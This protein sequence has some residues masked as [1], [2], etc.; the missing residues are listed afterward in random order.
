MSF[1]AGYKSVLQI[2]KPFSIFPCFI[3][4]LRP[5]YMVILLHVTVKSRLLYSSHASL[6]IV[7][8]NAAD[9][10]QATDLWWAV[11]VGEQR[12]RWGEHVSYPSADIHFS[13]QPAGLHR[14]QERLVRWHRSKVY[15]NETLHKQRWLNEH[16]H[17]HRQTEIGIKL[18]TLHIPQL[19]SPFIFLHS[20]NPKEQ[21]GL[22]HP[23]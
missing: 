6:F 4:I 20:F 5:E 23:S 1:Y 16:V 11:A 21:H 12:S 7:L 2:Y 15:R 13:R 14:G 18:H 3:T 9:A 19:I 22:L 10:D 17:L 8:F